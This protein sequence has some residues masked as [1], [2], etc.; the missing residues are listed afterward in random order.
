M[1]VG[2]FEVRDTPT[3]ITSASFKPQRRLAVIMIEGEGH[4]VDAVKILAVEEMLLAG[5]A[6]ALA[7]EIGGERA[8]HRIE[9]GD[10]RHLQLA[11]AFD[12]RRA[13]VFI[14][15][16]VEHHAGIGARRRA[17]TRSICALVR[18]IDQICSTASAPSNCT[19]QARA[20]AWTVS[21]VESETR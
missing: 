20:T 4:G 21:P 13:Q 10:G 8:D 9:H 15:E 1:Q 19:R 12:Q 2:V 17:M 6:A 3:R 7:A 11:A 16:G 18:T 14:D 5:Q